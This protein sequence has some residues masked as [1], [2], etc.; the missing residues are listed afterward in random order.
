MRGR[1]EQLNTHKRTGARRNQV[2]TEGLL[3]WASSDPKKPNRCVTTPCDG[4]NKISCIP[5]LFLQA[6]RETVNFCTASGYQHAQPE[7]DLFRFRRAA[8]YTRLKS[9]FGLLIAK[10]SVHVHL[11]VD[12][13]PISSRAHTH[14]SHSQ[15]SR[16]LSPSP[17]T[18]P[19]PATPC[20]REASSYSSISPYTLIA[21]FYP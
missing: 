6:H 8:F 7:Q 18:K 5:S 3:K 13:C 19:C 12:G 1:L 20:E 9:T 4:G 11:S 2:H 15:T 17:S 14:P 16:L 21:L 10:A